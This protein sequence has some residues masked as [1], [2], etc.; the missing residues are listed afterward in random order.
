MAEKHRVSI[1]VLSIS[2]AGTPVSMVVK[3]GNKALLTKIEAALL[4]VKEQGK[5]DAIYGH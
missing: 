2:P 5:I 1:R 4:K 3:K